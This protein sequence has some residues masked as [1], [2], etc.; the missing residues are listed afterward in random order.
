MACAF[1][2]FTFVTLF[3]FRGTLSK[4]ESRKQNSEH[5]SEI[6]TKGAACS[7]WIIDE[8]KTLNPSEEKK[9]LQSFQEVYPNSVLNC[10]IV[11]DLE[12]PLQYDHLRKFYKLKLDDLKDPEK[13]AQKVPLD[14]SIYILQKPTKS[15]FSPK[16]D[17][18]IEYYAQKLH[19]YESKITAWK[20]RDEKASSGVAFVTFKTPEGNFPRIFTISDAL[21]CV[22]EKQKGKLLIPNFRSKNWKISA[23]PAPHDII[24]E[25]LGVSSIQ[26]RIRSIIITLFLFG[27]LSLIIFPTVVLSL[28]DN[29]KDKNNFESLLTSLTPLEDTLQGTI[30]C[31]TMFSVFP[32]ITF[33]GAVIFAQYLVMGTIFPAI[34]L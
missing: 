1:S 14:I 12:E 21:R 23:A 26:C 34:F 5:N 33:M 16:E 24:W 2:I 30:L 6:S 15:C 7:V 22:I 25:N 13:K 18:E 9:L 32:A 17:E 27:T 11:H 31:D 8:S 3:V 4:V 19:E 10:T 20:N 29:L 28:L